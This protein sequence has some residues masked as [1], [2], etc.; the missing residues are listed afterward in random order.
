[1]AQDI[2]FDYKPIDIHTANHSNPEDAISGSASL[3]LLSELRGIDQDLTRMAQTFGDEQRVLGEYLQKLN[4]KID[5]VARHSIFAGTS[6]RHGERVSISE[7]G[8]GFRC[9]RALYKGNFLVLQ[10]IFL[11]S[12]TPVVVFAQVT[13]CDAEADSYSVA[14]VFY[15]LKDANRQELARQVLKAQSNQRECATTSEKN[16]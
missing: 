16:L 3:Q 8:V 10:I 13:R 14:A 4:S 12:Y 1:M 5:L 11:P 9:E 2:T 6:A 15:R 7:G